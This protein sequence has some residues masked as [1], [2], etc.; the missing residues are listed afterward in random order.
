MP[1]RATDHP[2]RR[3]LVLRI[4]AISSLALTPLGCKAGGSYQNADRQAGDVNRGETNGRMFD[5]VS[6]KPE[7]DDW[8]LRIRDSSMWAS[9]ANGE[10]NKDY[11][12]VNLDGR[13]TRKVWELIDLLELPDRKKGKKDEDEGYVMMRLRE[14][15]GDEGHDLITV[16]VSR[17]TENEDVLALGAYLQKLVKKY[18]KAEADF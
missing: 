3:R 4:L 5:F 2:L 10:D 18:H 14:P 7:G 11:G 12:T 17:A 16:F 13:E 15:G 6:N 9:Y 8:Q 1:V